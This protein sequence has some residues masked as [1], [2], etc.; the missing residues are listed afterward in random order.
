MITRS[1]VKR[2]Q[3]RAAAMLNMAGIVIRPDEQIEIAEL[4]LGEY[5]RTGVALVVYV[6]TDRYCG[7][8][9][10]L[11][12]YQTCPEHRHPDVNGQPGKMETFRC[13]WGE[14]YLYV[15]G[16]KTPSIKAKVPAGSEA[17]YTVFIEIV[18][19]PGSQYTIPP[20]TLHWFQAGPEGAIVTEFSSTSRDEADVFT[21]SRIKR[22]PEIVED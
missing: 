9:L 5:E 8:E 12:P 10:V 22:L 19:R 3:E 7:K 17:Y 1:E 2:H 13:R 6:N 16:P 20:D 14:V 15:P 4:G 11:Y 18:L 21:D